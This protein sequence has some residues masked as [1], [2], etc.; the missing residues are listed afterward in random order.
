MLV[1]FAKGPAK[2]TADMLK[3]DLTRLLPGLAAME[4]KGD[5]FQTVIDLA[6]H[7]LPELPADFGKCAQR[8]F[9]RRNGLVTN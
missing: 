5:S 2:L 6:A 1:Q 7:L 8:D 9:R 3:L 4:H